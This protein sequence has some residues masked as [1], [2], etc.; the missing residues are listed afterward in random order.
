[1]TVG[2]ESRST[3]NY[4]VTCGKVDEIKKTALPTK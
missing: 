1:M 3:S 2:E 4:I